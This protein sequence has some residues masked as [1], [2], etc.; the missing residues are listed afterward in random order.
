ML[1]SASFSSFP[2]NSLTIWLEV[3]LC[4]GYAECFSKE[5]VDWRKRSQLWINGWEEIYN[6]LLEFGDLGLVSVNFCFSTFR[7]NWPWRWRRGTLISCFGQC[8][9]GRNWFVAAI[10]AFHAAMGSPSLPGWGISGDPCDGQWQGVTCN[11]TNILTIKLN[12]ANLGGELGDSLAGFSSLQ[13]IDLSN[14]QIGGTLPSNLPV[15][16]QNMYVLWF[17]WKEK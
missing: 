6:M 14:N 9:L 12:V 11:D 15:T 7:W 8:W 10:N 13:T 1:F 17:P 5:R 3:F 4:I 16:L 2:H